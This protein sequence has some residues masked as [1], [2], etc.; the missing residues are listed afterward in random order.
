MAL[1]CVGV[2]PN[3]GRTRVVVKIQ[4]STWEEAR[5]LAAKNMAM[6]E[7]KI[8]NPGIEPNYDTYPVDKDGQCD[9]AKMMQPDSGVVGYC[10]E[11][12]IRG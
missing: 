12:T 11:F 4:G 3:E 6:V 9:E 10:S 8:N 2:T 5:S 1:K 7:S